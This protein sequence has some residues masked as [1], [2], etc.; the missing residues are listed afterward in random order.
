[1]KIDQDQT[2]RRTRALLAGALAL[3]LLLAVSLLF[4]RRQAI[5]Q[6][7]SPEAEAQKTI[8]TQVGSLDNDLTQKS[9]DPLQ[10]QP[11]DVLRYTIQIYN[12]S[13]DAVPG[14]WLI[15]DL[16]TGLSYVPGSLTVM[17]N[18]GS[19]GFAGDV[20]TWTY[21]MD[22]FR[23][24]VLTFDVQATSALP[25]DDW[26]TNTVE[27][28]APG[29]SFTRSASFERLAGQLEATKSVFPTQAR[30]GE[31]LTYTVRLANTGDGTLG[32]LWM[33]DE[34]PS[35]VSYVSNSLT[36]TAGVARETGG[37]I[38]WTNALGP[39]STVLMP[40]E[41]VTVSFAVQISEGVTENTEISN[42]AQITGT[43][44]LVLASA[45]A[46]AQTS[47]LSYFPLFIVNY[48]PTP[49]LDPIPAPVNRAYS[50]TW[51]PI[52]LAFDDYVLQQARDVNFTNVE[53][54]WTTQA[55][56]KLITAAYCGY[57][58][59]VRADRASEWG[60]GPWSNVQAAQASPPELTLN[61]IP[62]PDT[63]NNYVVSWASS[64]VP[65]DQYVLQESTDPNFTK[66]TA[67]WQTS[68][69]SQLVQKGA[70]GGGL[71]YY[72]VR[73][74]DVDCWGQ[75][76]W[77]ESKSV[78]VPIRYDFS[79]SC[80]AWAVREHTGDDGPPGSDWYSS[81]CQNGSLKVWVNDRW[82]HVIVSPLVMS[83]N[84]PY[85]IQTRIFFQDRAWSSGYAL[86]FGIQETSVKRYY[87]INVVYLSDGH[88]KFQVK[89][90]EADHCSTGTTIS[91]GV[92]G[93]DSAGYIQV[94]KAILNGQDWNT[95]KVQRIDNHIKIYANN[96]L[97][98]DLTDGAY[99]GVGFFGL[100]V[101]TWEFK[102]ASILVDY[103]N[104]IPLQ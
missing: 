26:I 11:G 85:E 22:P 3:F 28:V 94:D 97:L 37:V 69:P 1:M 103:Y 4:S 32:P 57:Y 51:E 47:Y 80:P 84:R 98:L 61:P 45:R 73:A 36:A 6:P 65:V 101:S 76:P 72:R 7:S 77:S 88:M 12:N 52:N 42:T 50:V 13:A 93:A 16:P 87:R 18:L 39:G 35:E 33:T 58:Y 30:P 25:D 10:G 100:M 40:S 8:V 2:R 63:N 21:D 64:A 34:L 54:T 60:Q 104:V 14:A 68:T 17:P 55:T 15:D 20:L 70:S 43:G 86:V 49:T 91:I 62:N 44:S 92:P 83:P 59:R 41:S 38:T 79:S 95:W 74:D 9:V 23:L 66:I 82:E 5:A 56:S 53:N 19:Y 90:C 31:L 71:F 27:I 48:P 24:V 102:P 46:R 89:R 81:S 67:V 29:Q 96:N 75:G 78:T 99:T